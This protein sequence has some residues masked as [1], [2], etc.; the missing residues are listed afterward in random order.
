MFFPFVL[1]YSLD[2]VLGDLECLYLL[3]LPRPWRAF[4]GKEPHYSY[5]SVQCQT[6]FTSIHAIGIK[7]YHHC[8]I[9]LQTTDEQHRMF[10]QYYSI[11]VNNVYKAMKLKFRMLCSCRTAITCHWDFHLTVHGGRTT[12]QAVRTETSQPLDGSIWKV[13]LWSLS[14]AVCWSISTLKLCTAPCNC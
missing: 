1:V 2:R 7:L 4:K 13:L 6:K 10:P 9:T 12:V 14:W 3:L 11:K 8:G 5:G